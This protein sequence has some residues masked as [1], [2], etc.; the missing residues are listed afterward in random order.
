MADDASL[1][2]QLSHKCAVCCAARNTILHEQQVIMLSLHKTPRT[3]ASSM[4]GAL[5][6]TWCCMQSIRISWVSTAKTHTPSRLPKLV[7]KH[8]LLLA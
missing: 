7:L 5:P 3:S 8:T 1:C 6:H 4:H 2:N